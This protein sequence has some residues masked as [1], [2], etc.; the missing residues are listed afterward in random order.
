MRDE[1][2]L[3]AKMRFFDSLPKHVRDIW[4]MRGERGCHA[5]LQGR[6][7]PRR[8]GRRLSRGDGK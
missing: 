2:E 1:E 4:N 3:R 6:A 5:G 8:G 7:A